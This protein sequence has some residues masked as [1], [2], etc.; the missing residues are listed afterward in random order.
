MNHDPSNPNW[1]NRD[2]LVLSKGHSA[3]ALFAVLAEAGYF[4]TDEL[5]SLRKI[6]SN[7]Q[8][9]PDLRRLLLADEWPQEVYP[10]RADYKEWDKKAIR[11]RGV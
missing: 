10:L 1:V 6:G 5:G 11:D 7:L 9:H 3:P 8:G 4:D 2:R